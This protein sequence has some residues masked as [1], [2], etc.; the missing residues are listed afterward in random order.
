MTD[1]DDDN[2]QLLVSYRGDDSKSANSHTIPA[3]LSCKF[4][5]A[6]RPRVVPQRV[7]PRDDAL[8]VLLLINGLDLLGRGRLDQDLIFFHAA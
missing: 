5:A 7:N 4:F 2:E 1:T 8:T 6:S 3:L